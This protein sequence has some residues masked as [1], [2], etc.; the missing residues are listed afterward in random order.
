MTESHPLGDINGTSTS[1]TPEGTAGSIVDNLLDLDE[2][3]S[4]DV[5]RAEKT[6]RFCTK[7]EL[8]ARIEDLNA[9]LDSL[10]DSQ[11]RS[12]AEPDQDLAGGG[13]SAAVVSSEIRDLERE[14]AAAMVSVKMR[15]L[16]E[17][18]WTEFL[19]RHKKALDARATDPGLPYPP[20]FYEDLISRTAI[21]PT[22][23]QQQVAEFRAKVG[24]PVFAEVAGVAWV[25]NTQSGVS[26]PKSWLSSAVLRQQAY[27]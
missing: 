7:P 19:A 5:R 27:S 4:G 2:F 17:D 24:H 16:D 13:R 22:F 20:D 10:T 26:V 6:A 14:Y 23:T 8:E 12:L 25:V 21:A 1:D 3:L 15:Q 9:E 11:G 18:E